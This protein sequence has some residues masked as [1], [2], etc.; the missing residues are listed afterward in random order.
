MRADYRR[1]SWL[2]TDTEEK[3]KVSVSECEDAL[4]NPQCLSSNKTVSED[5]TAVGRLTNHIVDSI[6]T[7]ILECKRVAI[8]KMARPRIF[9]QRIMCH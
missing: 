3:L 9:S 6:Y 7:L 5:L 1:N 4:K 2:Q 8:P